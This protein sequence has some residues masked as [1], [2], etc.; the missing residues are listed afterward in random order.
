MSVVI[1]ARKNFAKNLNRPPSPAFLADG[2]KVKVCQGVKLA[3]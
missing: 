3:A 1:I 2:S